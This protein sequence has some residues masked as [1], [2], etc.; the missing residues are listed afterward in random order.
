MSPSPLAMQDEEEDSLTSHPD[1]SDI[2]CME[3]DAQ[4]Y[5][6]TQT[7][8]HHNDVR[9]TGVR[10]SRGYEDTQKQKTP[11]HLHDVRGTRAPTASMLEEEHVYEDDSSYQD[12]DDVQIDRGRSRMHMPYHASSSSSAYAP[13]PAP[14]APQQRPFISPA[15]SA[16]Y[17]GEDGGQGGGRE[18]VGSVMPGGCRRPRRPGSRGSEMSNFSVL[19]GNMFARP[20]SR[21][22]A[23]IVFFFYCFFFSVDRQH[24]CVEVCSPPISLFAPYLVV[25]E[26]W[27]PFE[28]VCVCVYTHTHTHAHTHTRTHTHTRKHAHTHTRT[29]AHTHT[30]T[31]T[32][33]GRGSIGFR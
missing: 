23:I 30:R 26:P 22:Q 16:V 4:V 17:V 14:F 5:E 3:D 28:C 25:I 31:R 6:D 18:F 21:R 10:G 13:Y 8:V 7:P 27:Q 24:V 19:T 32:G 12:E 2:M 11:V 9:G 1:K 20:M 33:L 15:I 29:H